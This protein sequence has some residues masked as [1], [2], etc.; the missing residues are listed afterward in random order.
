MTIW[1]LGSINVDN[2]YALHHIVAPGETIVASNLLT[3]LGGKGANMSV[4]MSRAGGKV[5]HIGAVG[6]DLDWPVA[7]LAEYGVDTGFIATVDEATGHAIITV[8]RS[9]EN[10]IIVYS[11]A[12]NAVP[13]EV[14]KAALAEAKIG[15]RFVMQNETNN[16]AEAARLARAAGLWVA[17][18]AAPFSAAAVEAVL[19][20]ID[21]LILNEVEAAQLQEATGKAPQD[22]GV[23]DV[24]VTLGGDGAAWY[25]EDGVQK[26]P[27]IKVTPVDTTGAGDT[28]TGYIIAGLDNGLLMPEAIN[29]AMKAGAL[30]VMR[31]GTA[32]VIPKLPEVQTFSV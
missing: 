28:V 19:P 18:A 16:Q 12:N 17:Y 21:F 14:L 25:G 2:T 7:R 32:D 22:L 11:G 15:D 10:A 23:R 5:V 6:R 20:H 30:M 8:D 1:N 4:A 13:L 3:G 26:F 9:G 31:H 27:A 24:I 29:Q